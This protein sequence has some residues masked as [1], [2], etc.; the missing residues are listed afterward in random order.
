M[1]V[2]FADGAVAAE[3]LIRAVQVACLYSGSVPPRR[4]SRRV[5]SRL[6]RSVSVMGAGTSR[7]GA[8]WLSLWWGLWV[9]WWISNSRRMCRR[10]RVFQTLD[11]LCRSFAGWLSLNPPMDRDVDLDVLVARDC[12]C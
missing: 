10:W 12:R 1:P 6:I 8:A 3:N 5:F 7:N 4:S 11:C 9:L 2:R